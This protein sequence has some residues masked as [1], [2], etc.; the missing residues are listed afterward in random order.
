MSRLDAVRRAAEMTAAACAEVLG[1]L[2]DADGSFGDLEV[3]D[4][5]P[6]RGTRSRSRSSACGIKISGGMTAS[7]CSRSRPTRRA[8]SRVR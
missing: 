3:R 5:A 2:V 1:Q 8:S 7:T 6:S 4:A